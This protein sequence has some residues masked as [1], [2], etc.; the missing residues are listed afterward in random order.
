M[1]MSGPCPSS[2]DPLMPPSPPTAFLG[3]GKLKSSEKT[4]GRQDCRRRGRTKDSIL[5]PFTQ[6]P[7][8]PQLRMV[9]RLLPPTRA[10][11][12]LPSYLW[13]LFKLGTA[14]PFSFSTTV[15]HHLS[16]GL[17]LRGPLLTLP[18]PGFPWMQTSQPPLQIL[19]TL[20]VSFRH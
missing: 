7:H 15:P 20:R 6:P 16:V 9:K 4:G 3:Q 19:S 8:N 18:R 11:Q 17:A 14:T 13:S 5:Q 2:R 10:H 12:T 1:S